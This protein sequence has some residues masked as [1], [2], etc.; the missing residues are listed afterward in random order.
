MIQRIQSLFML[1]AIL[2][3]LSLIMAWFANPS[4]LCHIGQMAS[5]GLGAIGLCL[6]SKRPLQILVNNINMIL[7]ILLIVLMV[8]LSPNTSGGNLFPE[9][10]VELI[11]L[12]LIA[13]LLLLANRN[14]KKDEKLVKSVDRLR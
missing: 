13:V 8:Y 12:V 6:Y 1:G 7:N 10:A 3:N 5:L 14:I 9:K 11:S 2:L 4:S